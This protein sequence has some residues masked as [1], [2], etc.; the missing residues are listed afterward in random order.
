MHPGFR[1]KEN[2][3]IKN[4]SEFLKNDN[5]SGKKLNFSHPMIWV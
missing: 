2:K 4:W 1:T 3:E 5:K